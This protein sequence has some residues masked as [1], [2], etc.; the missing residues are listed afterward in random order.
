MASFS[1]QEEYENAPIKVK[2]VFHSDAKLIV[3]GDEELK[4]GLDRLDAFIAA[5]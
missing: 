1:C 2:E 3:F 5:L 4:T